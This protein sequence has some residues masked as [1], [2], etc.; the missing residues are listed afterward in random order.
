M[1]ESRAEILV[2]V[3]ALT[4]LL[5]TVCP[6]VHRHW[7]YSCVP[8]CVTSAE[9]ESK[10]RILCRGVRA[11]WSSGWMRPAMWPTVAVAPLLPAHPQVETQYAYY[12]GTAE[13]HRV[14]MRPSKDLEAKDQSPNLQEMAGA[15]GALCRRQRWPARSECHA[16]PASDEEGGAYLEGAATGYWF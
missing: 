4:S 16:R 13:K 2:Q 5:V 15:L 10:L 14:Y 12:G 9:A 8:L 3:A 1:H 6:R 11:L 7:C